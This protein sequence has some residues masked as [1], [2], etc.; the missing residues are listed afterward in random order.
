MAGIAGVICLGKNSTS[1]I[2]NST[3]NAIKAA[4]CINDQQNGAEYLDDRVFCVNKLPLNARDNDSFFVNESLGVVCAIDGCIWASDSIRS[5]L[6]VEYKLPKTTTDHQLIPYLF[7]KHGKQLVDHV[8]GNYNLLCYDIRSGEA[9]LINDR[10][11]FLPFYWFSNG[12]CLVIGSKIE[13]ILAS[14]LM[15]RIEFDQVTLAE[16]LHF[17]YPLSDHSY[18]KGISTLA[19][20]TVLSIGPER[21]I[22]ERYWRIG[23]DF[24][25]QAVSR[26]DSFELINSALTE[27]VEK[28]TGLTA[29]NLNFSLT[30]GWDSRVVL[31]CLLPKQRSRLRCYSFGAAESDDIIIPV[32]ISNLEKL[33]YRPFILDGSYLQNGFLNFARQTIELSGGTRNFKRAHYLYALKEMN[34]YSETLMTGIFGDEVLKMG[35]PQGGAVISPHA[36]TLLD[37]GFDP[38]SAMMDFQKS[39]TAQIP[40][41]SSE[42]V[43]EELSVRI[44]RLRDEYRDYKTP[45]EKYVAFRFEI[46]LRKYF[47]NE[48]SSYNDFAW[49]HSPFIDHSF[50]KAWLKTIYAGYRFDFTQPSLRNKKLSSDLYTQ[51]VLQRYP[52]LADY[53]SSRGFS[54]ADTKSFRGRAKIL[55][56]KYLNRKKTRDAFLTAGTD[57]IFEA[58]LSGTSKTNIFSMNSLGSLKDIRTDAISMI[59]WTDHIAKKF[60]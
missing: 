54:M 40:S 59:Y 31:A 26:D 47:G 4:L 21:V 27:A 35:R 7:K 24:T 6:I 58:M 36:L 9:F 38:E 15:S 37:N 13:C 11:G 28:I 29:G 48:A 16:H 23:E 46:N 57:D 56:K 30:G 22:Q 32:Q 34:K 5:G 20:A 50:L 10:L 42:R 44:A 33:D 60:S 25:A 2:D 52:A 8:N 55:Q 1:Q 17:N 3:L 41:L 14:G 12:A 43:L 53:P 51:L 18:V 19:N 49:C 39:S 45:S